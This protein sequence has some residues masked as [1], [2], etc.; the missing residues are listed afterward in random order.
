[1]RNFVSKRQGVRLHRE[2]DY[3]GVGLH[4]ETDYTGVGWHRETDYT[5]VGLHRFYC[6]RQINWKISPVHETINRK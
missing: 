4:R 1:M 3:T 5:G 6:K 2:T